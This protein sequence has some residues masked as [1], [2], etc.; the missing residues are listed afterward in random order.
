MS[1]LRLWLPEPYR[2]REEEVRARGAVV[3]VTGRDVGL[4]PMTDEEVRDLAP[5]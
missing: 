2:R 1:S 3:A 4:P 5:G